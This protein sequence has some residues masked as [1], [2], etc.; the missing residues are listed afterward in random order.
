MTCGGK[1]SF[2][3]VGTGIWGNFWSFLKRVKYTFE[4]QEGKGAF[5]GNTASYKGL[6]KHAGENYVVC[7]ELCQKA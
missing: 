6:L 4:F 5:F 7:V 1:F 2:S 3:R